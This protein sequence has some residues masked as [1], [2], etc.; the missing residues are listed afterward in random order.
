MEKKTRL[1][2][3][4][5]P[6]QLTPEIRKRLESTPYFECLPLRNED[7]S[8]AHVGPCGFIEVEFPE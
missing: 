8:I 1:V 4:F 7:G 3:V 6:E 5:A 2:P